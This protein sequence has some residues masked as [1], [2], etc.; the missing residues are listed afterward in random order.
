MVEA[1]VYSADSLLP[2]HVDDYIDRRIAK[3]NKARHLAYT[4]LSPYCAPN[5]FFQ[6]MKKYDSGRDTMKVTLRYFLSNKVITVHEVYHDDP[7]YGVY[8]CLKAIQDNMTE[9]VCL[10]MGAMTL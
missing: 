6:V 3:W 9:F 1:Q 4:L 2:E 10:L 8:L 7:V 5:C